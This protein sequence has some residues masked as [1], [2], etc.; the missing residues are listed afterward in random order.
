[1]TPETD[2][3]RAFAANGRACLAQVVEN[4][5]AFRAKPAPE[6]VHQTRVGLRRLRTALR[7]FETV[8]TGAER[9]RLN[10]EV[11]CLANEL[12]PARNLD[13]V[14]ED[15]FVPEALS[16]PAVA[17]RYGDRL[18]AARRAAYK[19][20]GVAVKS[21]RFAR[22]TLDLA[23][24]LEDGDWRRPADHA[25]VAGL[26]EPIAGFAA[27]VLEDLRR[28][29]RKRGK[30]LQEMDVESRHRLR[31]CCKR[32]RYAAE[33]F[34]HAF[35]GGRKKREA[36]VSA[37]KGLQN[38]LGLLNDMAQA[39]DSA[40]ETLGKNASKELVFAAGELVGRLRGGKGRHMKQALAGYRG[41]MKAERFWPILGAVKPE[42]A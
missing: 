3:T 33:F 6:G 8:V 16:D 23:L 36:F 37:L 14:L 22:L 29:V 21:Q 31:I 9:D 34:A 40:A 39:Q 18:Q 17:T 27:Q 32:L 11:E 5:T 35:G 2:V 38:A 25:R 26:A 20:A 41:L 1:M 4:A 42:T 13:V 30:D 24:W 10:A 19:R 28:T 15:V 12:G 7:L